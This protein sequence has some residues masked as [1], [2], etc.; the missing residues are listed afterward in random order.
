MLLDS[1]YKDLRAIQTAT[2]VMTGSHFMWYSKLRERQNHMCD[3]GL[4]IVSV[5]NNGGNDDGDLMKMAIGGNGAAIITGDDGNGNPI[6]LVIMPRTYQ[7]ELQY[8]KKL[9]PVEYKIEKGFVPN[10]NVEGRFYVNKN[11]EKLMFEELEQ[12]TRS[13]GTGF[14][15]AVKQIGNVASLPGIVKHSIGLPDIHSGYGFAIGNIAAFDVSDPNSIVSPDKEHCEEYG[16]MLQADASKVSMKAKK[17]GLPQLGTLGAGN[18]YGEVQVVEEIFDRY[19]ASKMGIDHI[20]QGQFLLL[21]TG[22]AYTE[23]CL[24]ILIYDWQD[25]LKSMAAAANFAWVNRSCMT[26]CVRQAFSKIFNTT[27][28]DLDMHGMLLSYSMH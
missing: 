8:I 20:G 10:M 7:E 24:K 6:S 27:P 15:P 14:L 12:S 26:F 3:S 1:E 13:F 28:D 9:S 5:R 18:H 19:A 25:Y 16:R 23:Q 17:R 4:Q 21:W 11:L 22:F 2:N